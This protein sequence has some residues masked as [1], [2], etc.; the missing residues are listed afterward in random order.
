LAAPDMVIKLLSG[1]PRPGVETSGR[2]SPAWN[3]SSCAT[4]SGCTLTWAS[5]GKGDG[6]VP[7]E[8][9]CRGPFQFDV[10]HR[11][12]TFR[13][14]VDVMKQNPFGPADQIACELASL[15]FIEPPKKSRCG[16]LSRA[17]HK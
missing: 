16:E 1:Q 3:P 11:V 14:S 8:I 10:V 12:A 13:D 6:S 4:S 2:T 5:D 9:H 15:Y 7:L 17:P